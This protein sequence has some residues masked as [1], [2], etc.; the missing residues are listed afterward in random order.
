MDCSP[1]GSS[2][3]GI[4]QARIPFTIPGDFPKLGIEFMSRV[5]FT[6]DRFLTI[7][8]IREAPRLSPPDVKSWLIEKDPDPGKDWRQEE[9]E[10]TEDEM[11]GWHHWLNG[12]EF[13]QTLGDSEWQGSL[14][15]CSP[16]GR[17]ELDMTTEQQKHK[18]K[19]KSLREQCEN[20]GN[21]KKLF[22]P[23]RG[24]LLLLHLCLAVTIRGSFGK[25][26]PFRGVLTKKKKKIPLVP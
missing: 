4:L 11:L 10:T 25:K 9:K 3:H 1:P 12:H 6:A 5:S 20:I 23:A 16:W 18:K 8:A 14:A 7:W 26:L 2:V 22:F 13:E 15:C 19:K 17:K 21:N 24:Y